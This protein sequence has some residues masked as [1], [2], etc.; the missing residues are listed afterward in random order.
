MQNIKNLLLFVDIWLNMVYIHL[1]KQ[2]FKKILYI[3]NLTISGEIPRP[4][5]SLTLFWVGFVLCSPCCT[6][7]KLT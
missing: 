6:G 3:K 2:E 4:R 5:N 7:I 1:S